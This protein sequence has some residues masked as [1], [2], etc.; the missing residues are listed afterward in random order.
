MNP[1]DFEQ[2]EELLVDLMADYD[3]ALAA[4]ASTNA[5]DSTAAELDPLLAADWTGIKECLELLDRARRSDRAE[6]RELR[7]ESQSR[8]QQ[9]LSS[10][11]LT[12]S[13]VLPTSSPAAGGSFYSR[14]E[15][16][17]G[18]LGIV[19]LAHDPQLAR[20]VALKVPRFQALLD[21]DLRRRFL[22]EAEA[23][24]QL[25]HP[26]LVPVYEVGED[27]SICYLASEYCPGLT[28]A[29]WLAQQNGVTPVDAASIVLELAGGVE[30]AHSR[31]VL[32]RD[33]KPSNVMM[34]EVGGDALSP[35]R[36][37]PKLT[38]FGMAKL[39]EQEGGDRTRRRSHWHARLHGA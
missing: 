14:A 24:A 2:R 39:L 34:L 30:H 33:I 13:S 31:G 15:L 21:D 27:N 37:S 19:Y 32:H 7:A 23:A 8:R 35:N 26:N 18:G 6:S 38:D 9:S 25:S 5:F 4:D 22:R 12:P 10:E 3:E 1:S 11:L 20:K 36:W 29:Q 28:L 16:G 17:R